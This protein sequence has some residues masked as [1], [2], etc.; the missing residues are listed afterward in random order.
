MINRIF[1]TLLI[2]AESLYLIQ[3][4]AKHVI[5]S[6]VALQ[7]QTLPLLDALKKKKKKFGRGF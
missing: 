7:N 5:F 1:A 3:N 4:L 6:A 2:S